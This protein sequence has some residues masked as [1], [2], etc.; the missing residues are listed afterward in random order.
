MRLE[1]LRWHDWLFIFFAVLWLVPAVEVLTHTGIM[2]IFF[3]VPLLGVFLYIAI[4][5]F[6]I[7]IGYKVYQ[8]KKRRKV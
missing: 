1:D 2:A 3:Y 7:Y 6:P 4:P 8:W 5:Y